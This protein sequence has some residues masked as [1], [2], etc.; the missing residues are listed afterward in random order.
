MTGTVK[1]MTVTN[2]SALFKDMGVPFLLMG[3]I[4]SGSRLRALA[5]VQNQEE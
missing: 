3:S 1:H 5:H 4:I 2:K